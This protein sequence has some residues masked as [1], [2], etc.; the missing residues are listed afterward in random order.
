LFAER[1]G[2]AAGWA[3]LAEG[4]AIRCV[5][6]VFLGV[7]RVGT[8]FASELNQGSD[9]VFSCHINCSDVGLRIW[10]VAMCR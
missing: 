5:P 7:I 1:F 10:G 3:V 6:A 2:R 4:D 8:T 9:G